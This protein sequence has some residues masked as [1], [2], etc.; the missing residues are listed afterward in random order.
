M[1]KKLL[2][3]FL[4]SFFCHSSA[5]AFQEIVAVQS[6]RVQPYEEAIRG[7]ASVCPSRLQRFVVS[8]SEGQDVL[9]EI[10]MIRPDMV[11]AVG[12]DAL[13]LV[14]S[15]KNIPILYL[16]VLN[17]QSILSGEKN[18]SGVSMHIS[19]EK[20][21]GALQEAVPRAKRI[22]LVYDP[23]RTGPFVRDAQ[24]AAARM[25]L[26]LTAKEVH[27]AKEA[28]PLITD[29]KRHIDLFWMLPDA[30]VITPEVVEF[31]LLFS[32]ENRIP[33]LTFSE[34]Y[35][36]MGAFMSTGIDPF[37][38]GRQAG[39]MAN[40]ILQGKDAGGAEP[41][42]ARRMVV[43]TNLMIAGKLGIALNVAGIAGMHVDEKIIR[44][45][46]TIN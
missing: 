10:K 25:G 42:H 20:Q 15:I 4:L 14:K 26:V 2:I 18:I 19:P 29:M 39:E 28:P 34:K 11:L 27:N 3:I 9:R 23:N 6:V 16:M 43:S 31:L 13:S 22:G 45:F 17:P 24:S 36:E 7:F 8:E 35:L 32:L 21:L 5:Q 37:D 46:V 30:T 41:V 40:K 12:R 1:M 38:M 44:S 33:L